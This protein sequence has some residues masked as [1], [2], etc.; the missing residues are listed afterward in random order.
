LS[1]D[2]SES[3]LVDNI[4]GRTDPISGQVLTSCELIPNISLRNAIRQLLICFAA[5]EAADADE[6]EGV[7]SSS[8]VATE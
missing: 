7:E 2:P 4:L 1:K 6:A 8:E 3:W 5:M